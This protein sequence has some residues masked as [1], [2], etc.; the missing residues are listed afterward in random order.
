M[1][2]SHWMF[3]K[4][5]FLEVSFILTELNIHLTDLVI[6]AW[7]CK[8]TGILFLTR[9]IEIELTETW[10]NQTFHPCFTHSSR[11]VDYCKHDWWALLYCRS[12]RPITA[13]W[14]HRLLSWDFSPVFL[15][16]DSQWEHNEFKGCRRDAV[17]RKSGFTFIWSPIAFMYCWFFFSHLGLLRFDV[18]VVKIHL[19][20][21]IRKNTVLLQLLFVFLVDTG[22][23]FFHVLCSLP[24]D[25][26][27][28]WT[29][30]VDE[31]LSE[32]MQSA[33]ACSAVKNKNRICQR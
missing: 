17:E 12:N 5:W 4:C 23:L 21:H 33:K 28:W 24:Q 2:I 11:F 9:F 30:G 10:K 15:P 16:S 27:Y 25:V 1:I 20:P 14:R 7:W 32:R 13:P 31:R 3:C 6:V 8:L 26:V 29:V 19:L 18:P 22:L